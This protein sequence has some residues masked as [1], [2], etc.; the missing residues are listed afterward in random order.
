MGSRGVKRCVSLA[1][2]VEELTK[3]VRRDELALK[4]S[5]NQLELK[6]VFERKEKFDQFFKTMSEDTCVL[7]SDDLADCVGSL[8]EGISSYVCKCSVERIVHTKCWK[9]PFRCAC[10]ELQ[11]PRNSDVSSASTVNLYAG[12]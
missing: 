5:S 9:S 10:G 2:Q 1:G 3:K 8:G 11:T 4:E 12:C 7:C 6:F